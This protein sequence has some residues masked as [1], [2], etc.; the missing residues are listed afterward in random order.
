MCINTF[1]LA[2]PVAYGS[3][4]ARGQ[5]DATAVTAVPQGKSMNTFFTE[6]FENKLQTSCH[7]TPKCISMHLLK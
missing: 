6:T 3:S 7:F 5:S 1:F 2:T 4:W